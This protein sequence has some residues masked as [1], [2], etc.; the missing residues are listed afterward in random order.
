M[1]KVLVLFFTHLKCHFLYCF[2]LYLCWTYSVSSSTYLG[3]TGPHRAY[4]QFKQHPLV[5]GLCPPLNLPVTFQKRECT[6]I[7]KIIWYMYKFHDFNFWWFLI[8]NAKSLKQNFSNF[9]PEILHLI[10]WYNFHKISNL[11]WENVQI[12]LK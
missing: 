11:V 8:F 5:K 1:L 7:Y 6:H 3:Q 10:V 9:V 12:F 4:L 2:S